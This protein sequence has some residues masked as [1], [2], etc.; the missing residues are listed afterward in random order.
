VSAAQ[1][2]SMIHTIQSEVGRFARTNETI[3]SQTKLLALNATIEAAR[4]GASGKGFAVVAQEVKNLAGQ[5]A[6]SSEELRTRVLNTLTSQTDALRRD[7]LE[8]Q[9]ARLAE[10][11]QN[12]VQL[13]VR[14]LYERTADV[15]WW[16][17]DESFWSALAQP[18]PERLAHAAARLATIQRFYSVYLDIRLVDADGRIV[19]SARDAEFR[20]RGANVAERP[21]FKAALATAR[22]DEYV[23]EPIGVDPLSSRSVAGYAAA[24]RAGGRADGAPCG[25]LWVGF[26]WGAQ[27]SVVV[28]K[29][30]TLE[31]SEWSH[32]RVLLLDAGLAIIAASDDMG[33]GTPFP[34]SPGTRTKGYQLEADGSITAFARTLGYQEFDGHGYWA[35]IQQRPEPERE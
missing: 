10:I 20:V 29:E 9:H 23:F 19:A 11:A 7:V 5:A 8:R 34:L 6:R 27:A 32:S 30:P 16:A 4:A 14:N 18:T 22:G 31:P 21:W 25:V 17:T 28:T 2:L 1:I 26:D 15:R 33:L 24:V 12:V 3:A 13:I 35:V